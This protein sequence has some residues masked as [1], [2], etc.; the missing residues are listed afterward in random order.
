MRFL[1]SSA[2]TR[3]EKLRLAASCSAADAIPISSGYRRPA[4]PPAKYGVPPGQFTW[5]LGRLFL[6]RR[7]PLG[8][9]DRDRSAGLFDR[10]NGRFR[11]AA[12]RKGELG[13]ELAH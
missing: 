4:Q 13:L 1:S 10:R 12:D 3:A 11:S 5:A 2:L 8:G 7:L 9:Q 6:C